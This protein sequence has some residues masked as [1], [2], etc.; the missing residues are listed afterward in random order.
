MLLVAVVTAQYGFAADLCDASGKLRQ[1]AMND[2][3]VAT[4]TVGGFAIYQG[5]KEWKFEQGKSTLSTGGSQTNNVPVATVVIN[6]FVNGEMFQRLVVN[7]TIGSTGGSG[8]SG[9]PCSV[10]HLVIRNKLRGRE[11]HCM[12]IDPQSVVLGTQGVT[13]LS[14]RVTHS[15]GGRYHAQNLMINPNFLGSRGTGVGDWTEGALSVTPNRKALLDRLTAWAEKYFDASSKAFDY[16]QPQ[17]A[18]T[19]LP[20]LQMVL[21]AV[22]EFPADKFS[23]GFRSALED[24]KYRPGSKAMAYFSKS[25]TS[26]PNQYYYNQSSQ[27]EANKK[28]LEG[29]N[30]RRAATDL[31][32]KLVPAEMLQSPAKPS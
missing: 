19:S 15:A 8:W 21:P 27:E 30:Q 14:V 17:D 22:A 6:R 11:D 28:A 31:E 10:D 20:S 25:E 5:D 2:P 3:I 1:I 26:T 12:T 23:L 7:S 9:S 32:C 29:C 18:Y 4:D 13:F 24:I 16:A